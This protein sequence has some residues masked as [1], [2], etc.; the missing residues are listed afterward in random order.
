MK[1]LSLRVVIFSIFFFCYMPPLFSLVVW[2]NSVIV[3]GVTD[4]NISIQGT[5]NILEGG[6]PVK[7]QTKDIT[8]FVN[9]GDAAVQAGTSDPNGARLYLVANAG[10]KISVNLSNNLTFFGDTN[11]NPLLIVT[12]GD[13]I[14]EFILSDNTSL[15]LTNDPTHGGVY[16]MRYPSLYS[17]AAT[18][19][20]RQQSSKNNVQ[21]IIGPLSIMSYVGANNGPQYQGTYRFITSN[22]SGGRMV[23]RIQD[24]AN[25]TIVSNTIPPIP[26]TSLIASNIDFIDPANNTTLFEIG[27]FSTITKN[28]LLVINENRT[29]TSFISDPFITG[30]FSGQRY[31]FIVADNAR[32]NLQPYTFLDYVGTTTNVT[33]LDIDISQVKERNSSALIIDALPTSTVTVS[34]MQPSAIYFRS[35]VDAQGHVQEFDNFGNFDFTILP[36]YQIQGAGNIILDV[37][38]QNFLC[39]SLSESI[40]FTSVPV[41]LEILS[42]QVAPAGGAVLPISPPAQTTFPLRTYAT[43]PMG[44]PLRYNTAC[45][46]INGI[47]QLHN[48][49]L[50]H[51]DE[52]HYVIEKNDLVSEPTYIG[53]EFQTLRHLYNPSHRPKI[54]LIGGHV[55]FNTSAAFTG[56]DIVV[57]DYVVSNFSELVCFYDGRALDDGFGRSIILGTTIG[58]FAADGVT[59]IDDNANLTIMPLSGK[60]GNQILLLN[61]FPNNNAIIQNLNSESIQGQFSI[62]NPYLGHDSDI[63]IGVNGDFGAIVAPDSDI[64]TSTFSLTTDSVLLINSNYYAFETRGGET[65]QPECSTITGSGGIFV[66]TN[67]IFAIAHPQ[68]NILRASINTMISKSH[69]G[70]VD[71]PVSNVYYNNKIGVAERNLNLN[72]PWQRIV[73]DRNMYLSDYTMYWP[74]VIKDNAIFVPYEVGST[75]AYDCLPVTTTNLAGLP[76]VAGQVDQ[77][78]IKGSRIGD[79]AQ[80]LVDGGF[81]RELVFLSGHAS[82]QAP[83]GVITVQDDA[84]VGLGSAERNLDST[85]ASFM[86]GINGV[87][88]IANGN[89]TLILNQDIIINNICHILA[90][91]DFGAEYPQRLKIYATS[92]R[93]I[94]VKTGGILDLSSFNSSTQILEFTGYAQLVLERG[95]IILLHGGK[96]IMSDNTHIITTQL[97]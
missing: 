87:T 32:L 15:I 67:G 62:N 49:C 72:I 47:M 20:R 81:I 85:H 59:I 46:L 26:A 2:N 29:L 58:S 42:L 76:I 55:L 35:G 24:Q 11:F 17:S 14:I 21:V 83:V 80:L 88:I 33:P 31:G 40:S 94:I 57:P 36:E 12:A 10:R 22:T 95:A 91:P 60:S 64:I 9:S 45:F 39:T 53:G 92:P 3:S 73:I 70:F 52:N 30:T 68:N 97:P 5:N 86:L 23:L 77:F 48:V 19:F 28:S 78:Q 93:S 4:D 50:Q 63:L 34:F 65:M 66:D 13:G 74:A 75:N 56:L 16:F 44:Q 54:V 1:H 96:L 43:D 38:S 8:I 82:G 61:T 37:E 51:S 18:Q 69:N 41:K 7:A 79:A 84:T 6:I 71:L 27:T 89:A 25:V 90:G